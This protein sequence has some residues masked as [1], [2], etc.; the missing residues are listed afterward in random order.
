[1][2]QIHLRTPIKSARAVFAAGALTLVAAL[3]FS[4][5][6]PEIIVEAAA[7]VKH[8]T[9]GHSSSGVATELL[10]VRYRVQL[11]GLDLTRHADVEKLTQQIHDAAAKGC[12]QIRDE[13]PLR[14]M[15]DQATCVSTATDSAMQTAR[16]AIAEAEKRAGH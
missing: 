6:T 9:A 1:M 7:P 12:K 16:A 10:S 8:A 13:Y 3:A 2:T 4:A 11:A 5:E 14:P 15:T